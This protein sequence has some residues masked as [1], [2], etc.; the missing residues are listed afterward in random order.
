[1][2]CLSLF[3]VC[4]IHSYLRQ[5]FLYLFIILT[6]CVAA[7]LYAQPSDTLKAV[8][9]YS[10]RRQEN[11]TS[12]VAM[13]Q[14]NRSTLEKLNSV[15][16]ADAAKYFPGVVVKDYGGVG[17]LKTISVRGL[18]AN[19]TALLY[20]GLLVTD[21]QGGQI[22]LGKFS[23]DNVASIRLFNNHPS[24]TLLPARNYAAASVLAIATGFADSKDSTRQQLG[25]GF[26]FGSFG[27]INPT[28]LIRKKIGHH[29]YTGVN[30][31]Y[32]YVKGNYSFTDY[33]TG[34][35]K[36]RRINSD[37]KS[38]RIEYDAALFL[39]DSNRINYKLYYYDSKRGLPGAIILYN[40]FSDQRLNNRNFF[41]QFSWKTKLGKK[42]RLLM[43]AKFAYD[44]KY[45]I[46]PSYQNSAGKLENIFRQ[47]EYYLSAAYNYNITSA[48]LLGFSSD[49][50]YNTLRRTDSF[51]AAFANPKRNNFLNNL[52]LQWKQNRWEIS[53]NVLHT[54]IT[55]KVQQGPV[56]GDLKKLTGAI[57]GSVQ[58]ISSLPVRL[59]ASFK[60]IFRAPT[61]DDLYYTNIGNTNLK[62]ETARL[63]NIGVTY[64]S[65][66]GKLFSEI[67]FSCD[68]YHNNVK[69]KIL[70][71][72]RQ[73]LFQWSMMNIAKASILGI[74]AAAQLQTRNWDGFE[75]AA[76][77]SYSYQQA[78]DKSQ[79]GTAAYKKQ[80][81]Y[82]PVHS[83][84]VHLS[85]EYK[86]LTLSYNIISSAYR[87][88]Q[89][90]QIPENL[91]QGW[92]THDIN[93]VVTVKSKANC[94]YRL[95]AGLN[96][97][98]NLQY[99]VIKYYPMPRF[100]YRAGIIVSYKK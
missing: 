78:L 2:Y 11:F 5:H 74:D 32:Q 85:A 42:S 44:Y 8:Q 64:N 55:E 50:F 13:Q 12:P 47:N 19:H 46:D 31:E 10:K 94:L 100:Q 9:L 83:G 48:L 89:G 1:M 30:A 98:Y 88:R 70:A 84:S 34:I 72:P 59:R 60:Q 6:F 56:A 22:D 49:Y 95:Q 76:G 69:D 43:N 96:N 97:V 63:Y 35:T 14:L 62:P 79:P 18:G 61:F 39:N 16:V 53:G 65:R 20:D 80:L 68:A 7:D 33:E 21:A 71:V 75:I 29:F 37:S 81:P 86:Q 27:F 93:L 82:I 73:N 41:S 38:L 58:P 26:Q 3:S 40:D 90:E 36:K 28:V 91:V 92:A 15:S 52:L 67:L 45:Y 99:E 66:G 4:S 51:A 77:F 87:Y 24:E 25:A 54:Y 57:A 17:G 23:L